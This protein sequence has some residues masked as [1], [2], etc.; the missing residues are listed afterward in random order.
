MLSSNVGTATYSSAGFGPVI[1]P[2][3]GAE[4]GPGLAGSFCSCLR[5][6]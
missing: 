5:W 6:K 2:G 4:L 1:K 3:S